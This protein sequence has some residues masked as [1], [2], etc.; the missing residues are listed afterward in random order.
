MA[1]SLALAEWHSET[2]ALMVSVLRPP[3]TLAVF[4]FRAG[5]A[6][7]KQRHRRIPSAKTLMQ[8]G[9]SAA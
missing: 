7:P 5:L 2:V 1:E 9:A 8:A 6:A 3:E 4:V